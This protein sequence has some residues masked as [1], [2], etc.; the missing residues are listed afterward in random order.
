MGYGSLG[1]SLNFI[2]LSTSFLI[3]TSFHNS[4]KPL[5]YSVH[6]DSV[7]IQHHPINFFAV[8]ICI[9]EDMIPSSFSSPDALC[10]TSTPSMRAK[11]GRRNLLRGEHSNMRS[12]AKT[13]DL[14]D[15]PAKE[16]DTHRVS[17]CFFFSRVCKTYK[18]LQVIS[19]L[20]GDHRVVNRP[21]CRQP[22]LRL[23]L[24]T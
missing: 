6:H 4:A 3:R 10:W 18:R 12:M 24:S 7:N 14:S 9:N 15:S 2:I 22:S 16:R 5:H 1:S 13:N 19:L 20:I 11:R 21:G 17:L 23:P 8:L